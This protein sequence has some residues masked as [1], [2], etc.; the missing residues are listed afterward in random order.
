MRFSLILATVGR[1]EQL[2]PLFKSLREQTF[3]NFQLI[4]VDQNTDDRVTEILRPLDGLFPIVHLRAE[5]RGHASANN[6]GLPYADGDVIH[7]P[8]D[9]C[10]Y[11]PDL[12]GRVDTFLTR[13]PEW[14]GITGREATG[15][16]DV[17]PGKIDKLNVWKRHISFTMFFRRETVEGLRFDESLGV[18]AGTKWGSGEESDF[19]LRAMNRAAIY[20]DPGLAV[21]HPEWAVAPFT[22]QKVAKAHSYGMGMGHVLRIHSY[23]LSFALYHSLRPLA[24]TIL[25]LLRGRFGKARFHWAFFAGRTRGW[26]ETKRE[27]IK[28]PQAGANAMRA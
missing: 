18:G 19:L 24:G 28:V 8:D 9:D 1:T 4:V 26:L 21:F 2:G 3:Q 16:W 10:W 6:V 27:D 12:F 13:H 5:K 7:F 23:P 14:G 25:S 17:E 20:Y 22:S 11:P 15:K